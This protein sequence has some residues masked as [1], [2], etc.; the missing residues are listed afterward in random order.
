MQRLLLGLGCAAWSGLLWAQGA[1]PGDAPRWYND[2]MVRQGGEL[3]AEHCT[4]CHGE[5]AQGAANWRKPDADGKMPPPPLNGTG[6]GW[7]HPAAVLMHLILNGSPGG[8]GN[9][10]AWKDKLSPE[11]AAAVIA[12]F[13]SQW[14][15][16]IYAAWYYIERR[17]RQ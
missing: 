10:P 16:E 7:H 15:D 5:S 4:V 11:Q 17:S 2:E 6:H 9:M 3:F 1:S 12:W 8:S 14:P 13:Q